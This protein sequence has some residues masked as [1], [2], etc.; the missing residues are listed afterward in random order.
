LEEYQESGKHN[1]TRVGLTYLRGCKSHGYDNCQPQ[2]LSV[3]SWCCHVAMLLFDSCL[4]W[5]SLFAVLLG[6]AWFQ[7][8]FLALVFC[9]AWWSA[10]PRL[11]GG[12]RF[13]YRSPFP[14]LLGGPACPLACLIDLFAVCPFACSVRC[15][16]VCLLCPLSVP[17]PALSVVCLV[18]CSVLCLFVC[19][20]HAGIV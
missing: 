5:R 13:A 3:S 9:L 4:V 2:P 10:C 12:P 17:L 18:A 19:L 7:S 1:P 15:L 6:L 14:V 20:H 16:S 11:L 8:C